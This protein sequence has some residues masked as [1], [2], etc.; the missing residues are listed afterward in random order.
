MGTKEENRLLVDTK[1]SWVNMKKNEQMTFSGSL[2][3][4]QF[5]HLWSRFKM[6]Q[7]AVRLRSDRTVKLPN[8]QQGGG[9]LMKII[10]NCTVRR[11]KTPL[12]AT[13][14]I[15]L[16]WAQ[17]HIPTALPPSTDVSSLYAGSS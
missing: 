10:Y 12:C 13:D 15:L 9:H 3:D 14:N 5:F 1:I 6:S 11:P 4:S 2:S 7:D 8:C 17:H 16:Y